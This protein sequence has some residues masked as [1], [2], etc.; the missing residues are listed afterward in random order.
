MEEWTG[1]VIGK[2]HNNKITF[3]MLANKMGVTK[4]YISMC[5]NC[6]RKP[7]LIQERIEKAIDEII[8]ERSA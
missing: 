5:L 6:K 1:A 4:S 8:A 3:D 2:M 7:S